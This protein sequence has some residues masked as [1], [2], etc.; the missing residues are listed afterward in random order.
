MKIKRLYSQLGETRL[1]LI[2][3]TLLFY[4]ELFYHSTIYDYQQ[5]ESI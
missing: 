4:Y 1:I 3:Q 5:F 2:N